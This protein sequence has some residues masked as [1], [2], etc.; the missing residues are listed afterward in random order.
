MIQQAIFNPFP[1]ELAC[2]KLFQDLIEILSQ[3]FY[4]DRLT[5][6]NIIISMQVGM[7]IVHF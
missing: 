3:F 5:V 1:L 6:G 2:L 7:Q 4:F